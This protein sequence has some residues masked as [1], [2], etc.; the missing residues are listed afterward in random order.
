MLK[1]KLWN[2]T[3]GLD[4]DNIWIDF[5]LYKSLLTLQAT[6]CEFNYNKHYLQNDCLYFICENILNK[7]VQ[8]RIYRISPLHVHNEIKIKDSL[9]KSFSKH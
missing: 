4:L 7:S 1:L 8:R 3:P 6:V 2:C 9:A 5:N